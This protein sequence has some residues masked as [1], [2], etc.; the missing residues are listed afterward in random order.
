MFNISSEFSSVLS[1]LQGAVETETGIGPAV[2]GINFLADTLNAGSFSRILDQLSGK[3]PGSA[4]TGVQAADSTVNGG[5]SQVTVQDAQNS[6]SSGTPASGAVSGNA[7][8]PSSSALSKNGPSAEVTGKNGQEDSETNNGS[9][10]SPENEN[11]KTGS[12]DASLKSGKHKGHIKHVK[13]KK[14]EDTEKKDGKTIFSASNDPVTSPS[15]IGNSTNNNDI[16]AFLSGHNKNDIKNSKSGDTG[17]NTDNGVSVGDG[18][19]KKYISAKNAPDI[20][21][22]KELGFK[23][24]DIRKKSGNNGESGSV[25]AGSGK[26]GKEDK[27]SVK[28]DNQKTYEKIISGVESNNNA[29]NNRI[30]SNYSEDNNIQP[31][32][33]DKTGSNPNKEEKSSVNQDSGST[34]KSLNVA[35]IVSRRYAGRLNNPGFSLSDAKANGSSNG[36]DNN[37]SSN[38]ATTA[39]SNTNVFSGNLQS[40]NITGINNGNGNSGN[41][42]SSGLVSGSSASG[43]DENPGNVTVSSILFMLKKNIHSTVITLKPSSLGSIKIN[44]SL[45]NP[46]SGISQ[47]SANGNGVLSVNITAQNAAARNTLQSSTPDLEN[48][49]KS[50][51][52][53]MV[54]VNISGGSG[55]GNF[56][57][58]ENRYEPEGIVFENGRIFRKEGT[59]TLYPPEV[60]VTGNS[61]YGQNNAS[62]GISANGKIDYFV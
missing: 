37:S 34:K 35:D 45:K 43:A 48:A 14:P 44:I 33:S 7:G 32:K 61:A 38:S 49:L 50:H 22:N 18:D 51:G 23:N 4:G 6:A 36:E 1:G 28:A 27:V 20:T 12:T 25:N 3:T 10:V 9:Q 47:S 52:F 39:T 15:V 2:Q 21:D 29:V 55:G 26:T 56:N 41:E 59:D 13:N 62:A 11:N 53:S 19:A 46:A 58:K 17:P 31:K 54:N 60:P 8:K 42:T 40:N 24:K 16:K 5:Q 30:A 57:G